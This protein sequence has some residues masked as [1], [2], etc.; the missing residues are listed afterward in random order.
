MFGIDAAMVFFTG[1]VM[2]EIIFLVVLGVALVASLNYESSIGFSVAFII[3]I[4][5]SWTG[6]GSVWAAVTLLDII[7]F[8]A[9]YIVMGIIWSGWKWRQLAIKTRDLY[10]AKVR[11]G[12]RVYSDNEIRE[13]IQRRKDYDT[14][15]FWILVW[16]LSGIG[17]L[18]N[19]FV[20]DMVKKLVDRISTI[21]DR[22]TDKVMEDI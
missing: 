6:A 4:T 18:I 13:E 22:I 14:F 7:W 15:V 16:P 2:W 20:V 10:K 9:I 11:D 3:L 17:Y 1:L 21:Y 19:D 5:M 8:I 12:K